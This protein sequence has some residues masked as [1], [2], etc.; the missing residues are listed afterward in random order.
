MK[1]LPPPVGSVR[2]AH[3]HECLQAWWKVKGQMFRLMELP[4]ELRTYI[5]ELAFGL[6]IYPGSRNSLGDGS[7]DTVHTR[8]K[9]CAGPPA[10]AVLFLN[11]QIHQAVSPFVLKNTCKCY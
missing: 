1:I 8:N 10:K 3:G 11:K 6:D 4:P 5:F 2:G 9:K 7:S